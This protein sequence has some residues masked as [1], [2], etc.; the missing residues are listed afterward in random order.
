MK[1]AKEI[2]EKVNDLY[3]R[4]IKELSEKG[5]DI[6]TEN[7]KWNFEM[8][9]NFGSLKNGTNDPY[10]GLLNEL[11]INPYPDVANA[12]KMFTPA[13]VCPFCGMSLYPQWGIDDHVQI[14]T[15]LSK[16]YGVFIKYLTE[17]IRKTQPEGELFD[18]LQLTDLCIRYM[19]IEL[20]VQTERVKS[21]ESQQETKPSNM[22]EAFVKEMTK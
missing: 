8:D 22:D 1:E 2:V 11:T 13:F 21:V 4:A 15:H 14:I 12:K 20:E 18:V 6:Q 19:S 7:P 9:D 3:E 16:H 5:M 17:A 10:W